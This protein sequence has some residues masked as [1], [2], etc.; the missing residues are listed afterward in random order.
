[1]EPIV[2]GEQ[3]AALAFWHNHGVNY[4]SGGC[5]APHIGTTWQ[6]DRQ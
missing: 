4:S 1:M 2:P 3:H 5:E 6:E